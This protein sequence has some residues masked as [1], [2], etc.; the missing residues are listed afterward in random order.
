LHTWPAVQAMQL[1][2]LHT[3]LL[4]QD[5]P[6]VRFVPRSVQVGAPPVQASEPLWQGA[7]GVQV[8]PAAQVMQLPA[9]QTMFVP[10]V[11]PFAALPVI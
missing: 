4:P 11:E 8:I 6:F 7:L 2:L 10:Q 1:P 9:L 3:R 5:V